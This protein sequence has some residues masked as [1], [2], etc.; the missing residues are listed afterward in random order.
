ME[1]A[2]GL[3]G[4]NFV[5]VAM[6]EHGMNIQEAADYSAMEF[7][8]RLNQFHKDRSALPSFGT[9]VDEDVQKYIFSISQWVVG[10]LIWSFET[11]R[12]FGAEHEEVKK[13][14]VENVKNH[15]DDADAHLVD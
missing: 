3:D 9:G 7:T 2:K 5:T 10:N 14:L 15:G 11:P 12:Y 13:T 6:R 4:N 8:M 1:R